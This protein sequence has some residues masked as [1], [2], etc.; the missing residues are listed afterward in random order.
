MI[1]YSIKFYST[2]QF[3]IISYID[4]RIITIN[5]HSH[6]QHNAMLIMITHESKFERIESKFCKNTSINLKKQL[7]Q[8]E[9]AKQ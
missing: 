8:F 3:H 9:I 1:V 5:P 4:H 7:E 2:T 6:Q